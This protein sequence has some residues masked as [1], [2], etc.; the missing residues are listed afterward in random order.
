MRKRI[1]FMALIL[2][3]GVL[4]ACSPCANCPQSCGWAPFSELTVIYTLP[5]GTIIDTFNVPGNGCVTYSSRCRPCSEITV[6]GRRRSPFFGLFGV[7][8]D[9]INLQAP[10]GTLTIYGFGINASYGL[11]TVECLDP[12]GRRVSATVATAVAGD[13]SWVQIN[14][15]DLSYGYTGQFQVVVVNRTWDGG[16]EEMGYSPINLWGRDRIDADGDGWF[17]EEDC[18]DNNPSVNPGAS[19]NCFGSYSDRNCNGTWDS[20]ECSSGDPCG[21]GLYLPLRPIEPCYSY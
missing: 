6:M 4:P 7:S 10:P 5:T 20:D 8:P 12:Y 11:P 16:Q 14:L 3:L 9:T 18:D 13:G 21:S 1:L 15:P 17:S 19:P 2:A